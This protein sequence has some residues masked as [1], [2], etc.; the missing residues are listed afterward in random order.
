MK[1]MENIEDLIPHRERLKLIDTI[2]SVDRDRAV[3]RA[4]V[5]EMWPLVSEQAVSVIILIE[6]AAQTAGIWIGWNEKIKTG[7]P[8]GDTRGWLV[9]VKKARFYTADIPLGTSLT[10]QSDKSLIVDNYKELAA[11]I[12]IGDQLIAEIDLQILQAAGD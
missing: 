6:L 8:Q 2:V 10:I 12:T 3:A 4:T 11:S 9:G 1:P 5:N 7:E